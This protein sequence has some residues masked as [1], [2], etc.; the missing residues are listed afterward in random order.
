M[1]YTPGAQATPFKI[2]FV[3]DMQNPVIRAYVQAG[4]REGQL[5]FAIG[6]DHLTG[7]MVEPDTERPTLVLKEGVAATP[8]T[9]A[10]ELDLTLADP[11][12][13]PV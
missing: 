6:T 13:D 1:A 9:D 11:T 8:G 10:P 5:T 4:L 2:E 12:L 7:G 3:M